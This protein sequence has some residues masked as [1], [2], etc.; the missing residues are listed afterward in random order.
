MGIR[1]R[2]TKSRGGGPAAALA[3]VLLF[4]AGPAAAEDKALHGIALVVGQSEYSSLGRLP[5]PGNDARAINTLLTNLGFEVDLVVNADRRKLTR[6]LERLVEDAAEADVA[7]IYYSGHGIEA[8]GENF[9]VPVDAD[10]SALDRAGE[11]L[12]PVSKVL[13]DLQK[14]VPVT[15]VLLDACR[16]NP[17]PPGAT[18]RLDAGSPPVEVGASGLGEPRG[19]VGIAG[20][21][22]PGAE[23]LGAV[24]GFAAAPGR[25]ALDGSPDGNSPYAGALLT[26][27]AAPGF[28]FSDVMTMVTEEVYL[29]TRAQQIPWTNTSL[30]RLLYFGGTPQDDA[31]ADRA[32]I[33]GERR[34][35]LLTIA[36]FG[37]VQ[38]Q[39]VLARSNNDGVPMDALFAMLKAIGAD[40]PQDPEQLAKLLEDQAARLKALLDQRDVMASTDPEIARLAGLANDAVSEG[41][42]ETAIAFHDRAKQRVAVLSSTVDQAESEL[43]AKRIEFAAVF[44]ASG[45]TYAL[46]FDDL[47][48]AED[49]ARAYDQVAK[50]DDRLALEYKLKQ[51]Q[52][53]SEFAEYKA[54]SAAAD[55]AIAAYHEA[56]ALAPPDRNPEDW[57]ASQIGLATTLWGNGRR[58]SDTRSLE[59]A[60]A[61]L[62]SAVT[63]PELAGHSE[64]QARVK[65]SLVLVLLTLGMRETGI[66]RFEQAERYAREA[67]E[68][69]TRNAAPLDW[70]RLHDHLGSALYQHGLRDQSID[71]IVEA[72]AAFRAALEVWTRDR[73]PL[74]WANT[75][76]NLGVAVSQIGEHQ[77]G[78]ER[79]EE[80]LGYLTAALEVRNRDIVPLAWGESMAN[81]GS[82]YL[83]LGKRSNDPQWYEAGAAAF[84]DAMNEITRAR[85]PLRWAT[86]QANLGALLT[87][88]VTVSGDPKQLEEALAAFEQALLERTR[89]RVPL[90]WAATVNSIGNAYNLLGA[91][92][93]N[94]DA[95]RAAIDAFSAAL[96]EMTHDRWAI[97]WARTQNNLANALASLGGF[98]QGIDS[99]VQAVEHYRLALEVFTVDTSPADF[100]ETQYN[101]A[102]TLLD[103]GR[104]T[105]DRDVLAAAR[106]AAQA[107]YDVYLAAGQHQYDQQ[108]ANLDAAI[109][110]VEAE[111]AGKGK[112]KR[113][114]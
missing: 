23:G 38:R 46:A 81:L 100:A 84:R 104:K 59:D 8:G 27:L 36:A 71:R 10:V 75:L 106:A 69:K 21:G 109:R 35:L 45:D 66:E 29:D 85:D 2:S 24:I 9:L 65:S 73:D 74:S 89:E 1:W 57:V 41:A 44:A 80:A 96:Q 105:G 110:Q 70:A 53:L 47:K 22:D 99:L 92:T 15:I 40:T 82:L 25:A 79:L 62:T 51:A 98:E 112:K 7:L 83:K 114:K 52:V 60:A 4:V 34:Q 20:Q 33:T 67:L 12:V 19:A 58:A 90:E 5:N 64:Q 94:P 18:V 30:R 42:L 97:G 77:P 28:A 68:V 56:A 17:F 32:A 93:R 87:A 54:D 111:L 78:T 86:L 108:F 16:S 76:N 14:T 101:L 13:A 50:W 48:A 11:T 72:E 6:A 88:A 91:L 95:Y 103:I 37:D 63:R 43:K 61:L 26:H 39:Q 102:V 49:F 113:K 107:S 31:D 3:L 55:R